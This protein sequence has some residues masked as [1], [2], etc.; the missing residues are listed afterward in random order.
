MAVPDALLGQTVSHYRILEKLGGGGMGVV[1]KAEDTRLHRFVALKF[2][3]ENL[4]RDAHSLERFRREAKAASA[5]NHPNI[6]TIHDIGEDA[7]GA[8]IVMEYLEGKTLKHVI[9]NRPVELQQ[10]LSIAIEIADA[11]NAA[12]SKGIVHRDIKPANI[13]VGA[14][15]HAKILDFGLAKLAPPVR[16]VPERASISQLPTLSRSESEYLTSPGGALGTVAYMSPEQAVGKG[17]DP[18]TDLFSFGAVLYEMATGTLPFRGDTS[19]A[20]FDAILHKAPTAPVR[21]NPE[22]P[23]PLESII[24]KC[25]EKD[26]ELRYQH[27]SDI[28]TDLKRLKRDTD[29]ANFI[30]SAAT[31]PPPGPALSSS[32]FVKLTAHSRWIAVGLAAF[33][34]LA[35]IAFWHHF[36]NSTASPLSTVEIVPAVSMQGNQ[37][38][39]A[40]S[41]D[42]KQLVFSEFAPPHS[43]MY[44]TLV[45]GGK[46]LQLTDY[47]T[48]YPTWSPDG[49][50]IAFAR[51]SGKQKSFYIM[52][53]LGGAEHRV[54]TGPVETWPN[55]GRLDWSPNG[56]FLVFP[57]SIDDGARSRLT[58]LTL[59]DLS[60]RSL[61]SPRNHEFDC[62]PAFSPDGSTVAF[63]RGTIG[64]ALGDL[65]VLHLSGGELVRLTSANSGGPPAWTPDGTEIVFSSPMGGL[66]TLW[67][68]SASGGTPRPVGGATENAWFPSISRKGN[69]LIYTQF[70]W[71]D[72]I[73]RL[74]L[75]DDRNIAGSPVRLIS[76]RGINWKPSFSPDGKKITFESRRSGYLNVWM[77]DSDGSDCT[78][79]TSLHGESGTARWSP[80]GHYVS[81]ESISQDFWG[82]Y[83]LELSGGTP[84]LL[85]TFPDANNGAPNWSRDGKW[86]YFYS[87][88]DNGPFQLWKVPFQG[89]PAIRVTKNGGVYAIE[90]YDG[91][92]IYYAKFER[93]GIWRLPVDGGEET[94]VLDQPTAWNNW[95]LGPTGI[96]FVNRGVPPNDRID[97]FDFATGKTIPL[98]TPE[99]PIDDFSGPALSPDGKSLLFGQTEVK[100]IQVMLLRNF[101]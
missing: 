80:D 66:R 4:A 79:L 49:S 28:S 15:G 48:R 98:F 36:L 100:E 6:C 83:L 46:P 91:H 84:R 74:D 5:L 55:C 101:R 2:L 62:E 93:P 42:G 97:F 11:L 20:I 81:F 60:S 47:P 9:A 96:Y 43:G 50:E 94:C 53:G 68:I 19:A 27:A 22:T 32:R 71:A 95:A 86:I 10:L 39:P 26:R 25:L 31:S 7:A 87:S 65:F 64:G 75:K 77:C 40:I 24:N 61:S 69:Q 85:P 14:D 30:S 51:Y 35:A 34:L 59:S 16:I 21:L 88:H 45:N 54:Y 1:Y 8:F 38:A 63:V 90:S 29:S 41:P 18:R 12:H 3:I 89:G 78:Q 37:D 44:I 70:N 57:E 17:I 52:P 99:K 33:L 13:F 72:S 82:V 23:A 73:W 76:S 92:F 67:R 58:I 56:K